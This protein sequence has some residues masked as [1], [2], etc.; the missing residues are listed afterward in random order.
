LNITNNNG[1]LSV[2]SHG[3]KTLED[4]LFSMNIMI[5]I[6]MILSLLDVLFCF[7][8]IFEIALEPSQN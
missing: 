1:K 8:G 7:S 6:S 3:L 4:S 2:C 5:L